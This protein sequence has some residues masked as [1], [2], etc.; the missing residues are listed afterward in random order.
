MGAGP[1][2]ARRSWQESGPIHHGGFGSSEA[3]GTV[4][5][6]ASGWSVQF[7]ICMRDSG[8][9]AVHGP[10]PA[11]C[12]DEERVAQAASPCPAGA[13]LK[14]SLQGRKWPPRGITAPFF[15]RR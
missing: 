3:G 1:S 9:A 14:M 12:H 10:A 4:S 6:G 5:R 13:L 2:L 15:P 11:F 7:N 8:R